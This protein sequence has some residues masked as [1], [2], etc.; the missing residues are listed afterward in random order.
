MVPPAL[1]QLT[2]MAA[3]MAMPPALPLLPRQEL[4]VPATLMAMLPVAVW[5]EQ[6]VAMLAWIRARPWPKQT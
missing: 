2:A 6:L 1:V 4:A 5:A 3:W